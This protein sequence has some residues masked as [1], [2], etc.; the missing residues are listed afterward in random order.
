MTAL[1]GCT[2]AR[3]HV[4]C[5]FNLSEYIQLTV[6]EL[7]CGKLRLRPEVEAVAGIFAAGKSN[8]RQRKIWNGASVSQLAQAPPKPRRLANPS[9]FLDVNASGDSLYF[10]KRDAAT[11]FDALKVPKALQRWFGQPAVQ[12]RELVEAGMS[13]E[14]I[15][16][17]CDDLPSRDVK[18]DTWLYPASV[19]WPMGF[20]WS[21]AVAQDTALA[22]CAR[23]GIR[24]E[25][26]LSPDHTAPERQQEL[27]FVA[28]DDTVLVHRDAT[29]GMQRLAAKQP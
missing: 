2:A 11:F 26:I 4:L 16:S 29:L 15:L 25:S 28:T 13:L 17:L 23:A 5:A 19:V 3:L 7:N 20:S 1:D 10:S 22:V 8:G 9:C 27:V 18:A 14:C 6:R 21:S 24:E 12:V